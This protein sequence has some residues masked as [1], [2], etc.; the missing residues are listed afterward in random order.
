MKQP[1]CF[2]VLLLICSTSNAQRVGNKQLFVDNGLIDF[3]AGVSAPVMD[4]ADKNF[5]LASGYADIGLSARLGIRYDVAPLVGLSLHYQY[6]QNGFDAGDYL[7]DLRT[8][9]T[10]VTF[11]SYTSD[12]WTLQGVLLGLYIPYKSYRTSVDVGVSGGVL[13]GKYPTNTLTYTTS[14]PAVS[15]WT[16]KQYESS[17]SNY[18]F[19]AGVKVRYQLYRNMMFSASADFTYCEVEYSDLQ[20]MRTN[21]TFIQ[22]YSLDTYTQYYH[23]IQLAAGIGIQVK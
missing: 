12:P 13:S 4:F 23:I 8:A 3:Q 20:E 21:G 1:V 9:F 11:N 18:A 19:Q 2:L 10:N 6:F 15:N 17:A 7:T 14:I 5:R 16:A 22:T